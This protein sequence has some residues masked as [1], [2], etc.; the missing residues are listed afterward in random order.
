MVTSSVLL[1]EEKNI[2]KIKRKSQRNQKTTT[3][4]KQRKK[5]GTKVE[6]YLEEHIESA[7]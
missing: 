4:Q 6:L 3:S 1:S 5:R 2:E 7:I